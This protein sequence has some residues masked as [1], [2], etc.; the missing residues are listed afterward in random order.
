MDVNQQPQTVLEYVEKCL[1]FEKIVDRIDYVKNTKF[2]YSL[3]DDTGRSILWYMIDNEQDIL[4]TYL[5]KLDVDNQLE[6]IHIG[7]QRTCLMNLLCSGYYDFVPFVSIMLSKYEYDIYH[8]DEDGSHLI[9]YLIANDN[10]SNLVPIIDEMIEKNIHD[11]K[12]VE[13]LQSKDSNG[14]DFE[15]IFIANDLGDYLHYPKELRPFISFNQQNFNEAIKTKNH[16]FVEIYLQKM[17]NDSTIEKV[18]F[19]DDKN[20]LLIENMIEHC[21]EDICIRFM[22]TNKWDITQKKNG[23]TK[24]FFFMGNCFY[25]NKLKLLD[26]FMDSI[27]KNDD[28]LTENFKQPVSLHMFQFYYRLPYL[29]KLMNGN[30]KCKSLIIDNFE[31]RFFYQ[32]LM[33]Q[34]NPCDYACSEFHS[35]PTPDDDGDYEFEEDPTVGEE[36]FIE[37]MNIIRTSKDK[38]FTLS[39]HG[40]NIHCAEHMDFD[41]IKEYISYFMERDYLDS[42]KTFMK[43]KM[44]VDNYY[45]IL[46]LVKDHDDFIQCLVQ[47]NRIFKS[48]IKKTLKK[49]LQINQQATRIE[50][51]CPICYCTLE[52]TYQKCETCSCAVHNLCLGEWFKKKNT[53]VMCRTPFS[54][55][56][57]KNIISIQ[58][59]QQY[60]VWANKYLQ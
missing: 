15:A 2:D 37:F 44:R 45:E 5:L 27:M 28:Y 40:R 56:K 30:E 7:N 60:Q 52:N 24:N 22:K 19:I 35:D 54:N 42:F 14:N 57:Q 25:H 3:R 4:I 59:Y 50:D 58:K 55:K 53:C 48:H 32:T 26:Y 51:D 31:P 41:E 47:N 13:L 11:P 43:F 39:C 33:N 9:S 49:G 1:S 23:H 36:V 29:M 38:D 21:C 34:I 46:D 12:F 10:T 6:C 18:D 20:K 16:E 17:E 8:K